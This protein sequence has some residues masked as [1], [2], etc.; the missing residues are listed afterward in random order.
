MCVGYPVF[1]YPEDYWELSE[2]DRQACSDMFDEVIKNFRAHEHSGCKI[3]PRAKLHII[4]GEFDSV[5]L[6]KFISHHETKIAQAA[7]ATFLKIG[8]TRVGSHALSRDQS[9]FF[10]RSLIAIGMDIC[11][12]INKSLIPEMVNKNFRQVD[13]YPTMSVRDIGA[14]D[15][16]DF[17]EVL[18]VLTQSFLLTPDEE[19]KLEDDIRK[20]YDLPDRTIEQIAR[21]DDIITTGASVFSTHPANQYA[22]A[23]GVGKQSGITNPMALGKG[24][25]PGSP[26][27]SLDPTMQQEDE[28]SPYDYSAIASK[29]EGMKN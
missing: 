14:R 23:A 6:D 1:E 21:N 3:P 11:D 22:Y 18:R 19:G 27:E 10:L 15:L 9:D 13:G 5:S 2:P 17:A 16:K 24:V 26:P 28:A 8:E 20:I 29:I 12:T 4:K 7:L 25:T